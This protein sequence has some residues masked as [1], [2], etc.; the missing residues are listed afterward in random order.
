MI[1][2]SYT[3]ALRPSE[4]AEDTSVENIYIVILNK[5]EKLGFCIRFF[6]SVSA[7]G[8]IKIAFHALLKQKP[9]HCLWTQSYSLSSLLISSWGAIICCQ[10]VRQQTTK[11][12]PL[13]HRLFIKELRLIENLLN[14]NVP[15]MLAETVWEFCFPCEGFSKPSG[16][17]IWQSAVSIKQ[18][19]KYQ[20]LIW[21]KTFNSPLI[22]VR[23]NS[24]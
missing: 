22:S 18:L 1:S 19:I 9:A 10:N 17:K 20:G 21:R 8:N 5:P 16:A 3:P 2:W 15:L 11:A 6:I 14:T 13:Y 7:F 12:D 24:H 23:E 4:P